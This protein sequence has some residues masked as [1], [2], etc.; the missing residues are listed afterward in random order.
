MRALSP[1]PACVISALICCHHL[2]AKSDSVNMLD[3]GHLSSS[4]AANAAWRQ[5]TEDAHEKLEEGKTEQQESKQE[6][7]IFAKF[8]LNYSMLSHLHTHLV[9]RRAL[10]NSLGQIYHLYMSSRVKITS[11]HTFTEPDYR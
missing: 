4:S 11:A 8:Q 2:P 7:P 9:P 5:Q 10:Y 6:D 1:N 3:N